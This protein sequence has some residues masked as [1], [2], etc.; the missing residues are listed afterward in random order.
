MVNWNHQARGVL[1]AELA[2]RSVSYKRLVRLLEAID[3]AETEQS[4]ANKLSRGTFSFAFF[5]QCMQ[6]I[7]A[8]HLDLDYLSGGAE[9]EPPRQ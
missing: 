7:G 5:L 4:I 8:R 2:R 9:A 1:K 3:V 6:A